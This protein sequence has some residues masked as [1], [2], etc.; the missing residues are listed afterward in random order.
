[1]RKNDYTCN[2][3]L[4]ELNENIDPDEEKA[5]PIDERTAHIEF[6]NEKLELRLTPPNQKTIEDLM[7]IGDIVQT[8][9]ETGPYRVEKISKYKV[10]GL[11]VYSLVLSRPN[12][13]RNA[14]G[15]LPK[16]Y[17]YYYLN[18]L[19]AQDNKILCLF[20]N[21]KDEVSIVKKATTLKSFVA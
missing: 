14:D 13:K 16:D 5:I 20:K 12:D 17:G 8:N 2:S 3:F 18:E 15:K 11:P 6:N 19:V 1:M 9:Y 21:N 7:D 10:Y 4:A